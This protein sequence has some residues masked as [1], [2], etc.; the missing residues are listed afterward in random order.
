M[1]PPE[2]SDSD[3][4]VADWHAEVEQGMGYQIDWNLYHAFFPAC[5][6]DRPHECPIGM[7]CNDHPRAD[8]E[9]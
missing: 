3:V 2:R 4:C 6:A 1:T 7:A 8:G 9:G 5:G